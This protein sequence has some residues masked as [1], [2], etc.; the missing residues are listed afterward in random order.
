MQRLG[1][2]RRRATLWAYSGHRKARKSNRW[3]RKLETIERAPADTGSTASADPTDIATA[4]ASGAIARARLAFAVERWPGSSGATLYGATLGVFLA[5]LRA[6]DPA[7]AT[8]LHDGTAR[9][10]FA[11]SPLRITPLAGNMAR[12]EVVVAL[13]DQQLLTTLGRGVNAA[14][15]ATLEVAGHPAHLLDSEVSE[16]ASFAT[17]LTA[18]ADG[19]TLLWARFT[20]P[21][22]FSWG[23][24][25]DGRHR[26]GLLPA[27]E[28]VVGSWLR[29]WN[30]GSGPETPFQ[31]DAE[32]LRE[33]IRIQAIR[34][35]RTAQ[36]HTGKT[37]MS[38][39]VGEVAYEW[40]G[41]TPG[42]HRA[43]RALGSFARYCGTGA[44]TAYGLGQTETRTA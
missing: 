27:P 1:P 43:L 2:W 4:K 41:A 5:L 22:V 7:V 31:E 42:G 24:G 34:S 11:L 38:G 20:T 10:R 16:P 36:A 9:K 13:W 21:T 35:L 17:L 23:R 37:P 33:R 28:H 18:P 14:L 25:V 44:K 8:E 15:D 12:A 26:Y 39:F 30:A 29:A 32:W 6:G 3:R 19:Q 40:C